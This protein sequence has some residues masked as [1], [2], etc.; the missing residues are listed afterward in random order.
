MADKGSPH[1]FAALL[2]SACIAFLPPVCCPIVGLA[3]SG[4]VCTGRLAALWLL[5][6][7]QAAWLQLGAG[8]YAAMMP[9][10]AC[11]NV[12]FSPVPHRLPLVLCLA[13]ALP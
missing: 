6:G 11:R 9:A 2:A 7:Y 5:C 12:R 3:A 13:P 1:I 4:C 10:A 8:I